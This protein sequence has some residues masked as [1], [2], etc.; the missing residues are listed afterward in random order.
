M[1]KEAIDLILELRDAAKPIVEVVGNRSYNV[2]EGKLFP[3]L[4]PAVDSMGFSTLTGLVAWAEKHAA[5][6]IGKGI[7][8]TTKP[9]FV[10]DSFRRVSLYSPVFGSFRQRS[11]IAFA[12]HEYNEFPYGQFMD[13]A[14]LITKTQTRFKMEGDLEK[15]LAIVGSVKE[16]DIR[17]NNDDGITQSVVARKSIITGENVDLPNPVMLKPFKTFAEI[18]VPEIAHVFRGETGL[19]WALFETDDSQWKKE[20]MLRVQTWLKKNTAFEVYA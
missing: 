17:Q 8:D 14:T 4:E 20:A 5:D 7:P 16:E 19:R 11:E 18:E 12:F 9:Y 3:I 1:I 2:R 10:V 13:T 6:A 15:L